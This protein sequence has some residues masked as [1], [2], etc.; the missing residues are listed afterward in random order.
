[1]YSVQVAPWGAEVMVAPY[2]LQVAPWGA[3]VVVAPYQ[4]QVA[5]KDGAMHSVQV[6][7]KDGAMHSV[8]V[9][10]KD[11]AM[12]SKRA[13]FLTRY[14]RTY[15]LL[16]LR[17]SSVEVLHKIYLMRRHMWNKKRRILKRSGIMVKIGA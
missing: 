13:F 9:A 17:F 5:L 12:S 10:L 16:P 8:Q 4:I 11:G 14:L 2:Q 7:L 1:M 15:L 3:E 6:A